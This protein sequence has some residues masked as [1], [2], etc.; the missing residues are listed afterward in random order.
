MADQLILFI[1]LTTHLFQLLGRCG[2]TLL[3]A[4]PAYRHSLTLTGASSTQPLR[5]Q[6]TASLNDEFLVSMP[7]IKARVLDGKKLAKTIRSE[8]ASEVK[9]IKAKGNRCG[10]RV[11]DY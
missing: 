10:L 4:S 2:R 5:Q 11:I 1:K 7:G 8:I 3:E 6:G 9:T